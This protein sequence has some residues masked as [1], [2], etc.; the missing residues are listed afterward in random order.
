MPNYHTVAI[1]ICHCD[2]CNHE[3]GVPLTK[4]KREGNVECPQCGY[5]LDV[6]YVTDD[7]DG[8]DGAEDLVPA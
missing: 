4:A 8:A 2:L 3:W 5:E 7:C 1:L 6:R